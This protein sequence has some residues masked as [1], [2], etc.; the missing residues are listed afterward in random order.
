MLYARDGQTVV[1]EQ[2]WVFWL[3]WFFTDGLDVDIHASV[4]NFSFVTY[5]PHLIFIIYFREKVATFFTRC[6]LGFGIN[7]YASRGSQ[8][9]Q[10]SF[11]AVATLQPKLPLYFESSIFNSLMWSQLL[12]C[13][14]LSHLQP[15]SS[16]TL[17]QLWSHHPSSICLGSRP[18]AV[19]LWTIGEV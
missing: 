19:C 5:R 8:A 14:Q 1:L 15:Q 13:S 4:M 9:A 3:V 11:H 16:Q 18:R 17:W 10:L 6:C 12:Q 7:T 2:I